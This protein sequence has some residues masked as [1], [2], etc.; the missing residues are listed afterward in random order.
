MHSICSSS[1]F[2]LTYRIWYLSRNHIGMS[3]TAC[4]W[5]TPKKLVNIF[6]PW[7]WYSYVL[8]HA[9]I[10]DNP[11]DI[12]IDVHSVP[13]ETSPLTLVECL[14][15][16]DSILRPQHTQKCTKHLQL[17]GSVLIAN[18]RP[19]KRMHFHFSLCFGNQNWFTK[20][21]NRILVKES[22]CDVVQK[23]T[24]IDGAP[25]KFDYFVSQ[26]IIWGSCLGTTTL[27]SLSLCI[28]IYMYAYAHICSYMCDYVY[29]YICSIIEQSLTCFDE[30]FPAK[31]LCT[32]RL[33]M[34]QFTLL[35]GQATTRSYL[36]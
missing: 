19:I 35:K 34:A 11:F 26:G 23:K 36:P 32:H 17:V 33:T 18:A 15:T 8:V 3:H 1:T 13:A 5:W 9:H 25:P 24:S 28:Y 31:Q 10:E 6:I 27:L 21:R 20:W 12:I 14:A 29:I 7:Q 2:Y 22:D 16:H 30:L 4:P